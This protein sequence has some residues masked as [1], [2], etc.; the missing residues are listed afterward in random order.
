MK[1]R[2]YKAFDF[3][4]G[5]T[6]LIGEF[7]S[8]AAAMGYCAANGIATIGQTCVPLSDK[9]YSHALATK[10]SKEKEQRNERI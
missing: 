6:Y 9:E 2:Q 4:S 7:P 10:K 8:K 5:H 1:A 3:I